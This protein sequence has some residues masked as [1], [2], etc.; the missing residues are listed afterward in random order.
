LYALWRVHLADDAEKAGVGRFLWSRFGVGNPQYQGLT[1]PR[2]QE[3]PSGRVF[4][5]RRTFID[6]GRG[7]VA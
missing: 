3:A 1:E 5:T 4:S 2:P 7:V 6:A